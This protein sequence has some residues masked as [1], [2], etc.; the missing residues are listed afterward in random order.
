[1]KDARFP[2]EHALERDAATGAR[3]HRLTG[4]PCI[5]HHT[6]FLNSSLTPDERAL[7]FS[8]NRTGGW[9]LYS[10]EPFP[11]GEI[12]QWTDGAPIH[13][14]S[15]AIHPAGESVFFVRGGS[16][17]EIRRDKLEERLVISRDD[18][19]FGEVSLSADG[20]WLTAAAKIGAEPGI[21]AGRA[22]GREWTFHRFPRT[23]IHPQFHPL[24]PEWIEF[25]ADPAPRMHRIRRD[26]TGIECLYEHSNEEFVVHET[27]LGRT[28]DLVYVEW[29][30]ALWRMDWTTRERRLICECNAWHIAPNR[31]GTLILC[32]TNHPDR[33]LFLID[34][35]TGAQRLAALSQ[36]SNRGSQWARSRYAL[37]EDF[38]AAR[39]ALGGNLSW[40]EN[41]A[42]TVYGPQY[43]HPH[44]SF[45]PSERHVIFTSDRSGHPQVYAVELDG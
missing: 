37:P 24:E 40:M 32:D 14:F 10:V 44:P 31:A 34:A 21:V 20:G 15:P 1:M 3:V 41:A 8:S 43:T 16:I 17:W 33:G 7:I 23:V 45:S 5:N 22:D 42:D 27:F 29:P 39:A 18:A 19:Q 11:Q 25:A 36:S 12:R 2:S 35:A 9:Q 13:P 6:Y 30:R 28:G 26:G 4:A 38:A